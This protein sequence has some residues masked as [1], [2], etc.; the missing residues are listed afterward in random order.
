DEDDGGGA[1]R[2]RAPQDSRA[3]LQIGHELLESDPAPDRARLFLRERRVAELEE[4]APAR[5]AWRFTTL[6]AIANR[7]PQVRFDLLVDLH[8]ASA[9]EPRT[10]THGYPSC[11]RARMSAWTASTSCRKR[12]CSRVR[13]RRPA[14]VSR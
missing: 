2:G 7:H 12:E 4:R 13:W 10:K 11:P 8:V 3:D 5:V 9:A 6:D 14:G 1:E